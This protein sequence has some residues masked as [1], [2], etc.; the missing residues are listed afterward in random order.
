MLMNT[1]INM[2]FI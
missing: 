2:L 1:Y